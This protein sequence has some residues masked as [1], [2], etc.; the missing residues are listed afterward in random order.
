MT[1]DLKSLSL[2]H[3]ILIRIELRSR[4]RPRWQ[5]AAAILAGPLLLLAGTV[6]GGACAHA[7]A[8]SEPLRVGCTA[9]G[10]MAHMLL[11]L[12]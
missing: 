1:V 11:Q 10:G 4:S 7:L 9:F 5:A 8:A 6:A 12:P 2:F 3:T